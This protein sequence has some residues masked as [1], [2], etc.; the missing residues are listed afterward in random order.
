MSNSAILLGQKLADSKLLLSTLKRQISALKSHNFESDLIQENTKLKQQVQHL[1][2]ELNSLELKN[3]K[4]DTKIGKKIVAT[5]E[6]TTIPAKNEAPS[7]PKT[8]AA[9]PDRVKKTAPPASEGPIDVSR[10]DF[11]IGRIVEVSKHPDGDSLYVEKVDLGENGAFRTVVSGL[12][13]HVTIE[14]MHNKIA[15]FM[16]NL[17]PAKIRGIESQAMIMCASGESKTEI[18]AVPAG[19]VPGDRVKAEGYADKEPDE[20]LNP[21]KK[22]WE[23]VKPDL[24]VDANGFAT[25]KGAKWFVGD[26]GF[27]RAPTSVD[28]QIS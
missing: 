12:V 23:Q 27:V 13:K 10:L 24:R 9:A 20:Q 1:L 3:D 15:V 16:C 14:E 8:Q 2:A 6:S 19:V 5:S 17:K 28:V 18:L 22:I 7:Q 25:Y 26:K 21:K 4:G 11:R